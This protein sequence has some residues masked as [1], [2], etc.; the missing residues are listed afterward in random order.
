MV[1]NL[2]MVG[3]FKAFKAQRSS[4]DCLEQW[5]WRNIAT[6]ATRRMPRGASMGPDRC[7]AAQLKKRALFKRFARLPL[8]HGEIRCAEQKPAA[9]IAPS[10]FNSCSG[11][12]CA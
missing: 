3:T 6:A 2:I 11:C 4:L 7:G 10:I 1:D 8:A 9:N 12:K 5:R